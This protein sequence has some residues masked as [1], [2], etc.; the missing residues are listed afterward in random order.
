MVP[1]APDARPACPIVLHSNR[2]SA[3]DGLCFRETAFQG[4]RHTAEMTAASWSP[5]EIVATHSHTKRRSIRRMLDSGFTPSANAT[6]YLAISARRDGKSNR[7]SP[8]D[9]REWPKADLRQCPVF[10]RSWGQSGH[11][12][13]I[14]DRFISTR[15]S[16]GIEHLERLP[17]GR[18]LSRCLT[19][20]FQANRFAFTRPRGICC[21]SAFEADHVRR[22]V[23]CV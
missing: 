11:Q 4:Q 2:V 15:P 1:P 19:R 16:K 3:S 12:P 22:D 10:G 14:A 7:R 8:R 5:D 18:K 13:A 21:N 6:R 9:C 20:H 17:A 23:S